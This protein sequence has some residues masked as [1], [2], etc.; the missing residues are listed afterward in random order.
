MA[1][2]NRTNRHLL[3]AALLILGLIVAGCQRAAPEQPTPPPTKDS[4]ETDPGAGGGEVPVSQ[5][6]TAPPALPTL[7]P[8]ESVT[9]D[10]LDIFVDAADAVIVVGRLRNSTSATVEAISINYTFTDASGNALQTISSEVP[11]VY[12]VPS[13]AVAPFTYRLTDPPAGLD[14]VRVTVAT[15]FV[16]PQS[17]LSP[18][19]S[20]PTLRIDDRGVAHCLAEISNPL[21]T[22]MQVNRIAAEFRQSDGRLVLVAPAQ[23]Y[24]QVLVPGA[25]SPVRASADSIRLG[26]T[27]TG[28]SLITDVIAYTLPIVDNSDLDF[29]NQRL[30][31]SAANTLHLIGAVENNSDIP[32]SV[33]LVAGLYDA[34]GQLLDVSR[35]TLPLASLPPESN[36]PFDFSDFQILLNTTGLAQTVASLKLQADPYGTLETRRPALGVDVSELAVTEDAVQWLVSGIAT[37]NTDAQLNEVLVYAPVFDSDGNFAAYGS[38]RLPSPLAPGESRDFSFTVWK[39]AGVDSANL[40]LNVLAFGYAP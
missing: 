26:T 24:T 17:P 18:T 16:S 29:R 33:E 13:G 9:I 2:M 22:P 14:T 4:V 6:P 36:F 12:Y 1:T 3:F 28:C 34:G 21:G 27:I 30:S 31:L 38:V 8:G 32:F 7:G 40:G 39:P 11:L 5:P 20:T 19:V 25:V 15:A 23:A 10:F 37:N 35:Y